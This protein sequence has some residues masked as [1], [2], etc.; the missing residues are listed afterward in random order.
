MEKKC[1]YFKI[2]K[3]RLN[4]SLWDISAVNI[5]S[6]LSPVRTTEL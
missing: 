3:K 5:N 1:V 2:G 4:I 6:V